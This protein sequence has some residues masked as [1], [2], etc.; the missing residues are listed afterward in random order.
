MRTRLLA[1]A[2]LA[3]ALLGLGPATAGAAA[4]PPRDTSRFAC[5]ASLPDP[6]TDVA[7]SVHEQ[8]IR[9]LAL[10]GFINGT[11]ST[12]FTPGR[13]VTRGQL[14]SFIARAMAWSGFPFDTSDQGFTD[15]AGSP[16]RDAINGLAAA[17]IIR[18]TSATTFSPNRPVTRAQAASLIGRSLFLEGLPTGEDVFSDDEGSV[19]EE[20]INALASVGIVA[21]VT[22]DR[23]DPDGDVTRGAAASMVARAN[24]FA[25][26]AQLSFP[27][28]PAESLLAALRGAAE[29]PGPGDPIGGGTVEL[30]K[31]AVDGLLCL[32]WD[33]DHPLADAPTAAHVH[34]GGAGV[35]GPIHLTLP[36]PDVAAGE[37]GFETP[38][39]P[40]L[41]QALIDEVFANPAGFYV[42]VHTAAFP[43]GAVRGQ[44]S[45]VGTPLGTRLAGTEEVPGPG[46]TAAGGDATVDTLAD[47]TTIC[48]FLFYDGVE[49]PLAAHIHEAAAGA[50][51][52]IVVTLPPFDPEGGVSDG[53]VGGLDAAL[54]TDLA[55][56]PDD[57]YVNVHTDGHPAGAVRG[58]L[59]TSA[60]LAAALGGA[61]EVPGPGDPDGAGEAFL[62]LI[63]D[64]LLCVRL[65]VRG[66]GTPT[67]AHIHDGASGVA[68]PIVVTLPTPT[69]NAS[70]DCIDVP[71]AVYADIAAN[72]ADF[73][74]NVHNAEHPA[75]AVRGQ[76][77]VAHG[78]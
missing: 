67:A 5:P 71:P 15:V 28:G 59:A 69:F 58:Q 53:C 13:A 54:V 50:A 49:E 38:C 29:V 44:L 70:F 62:D 52:P 75:G 3:T 39:V 72:P 68:G 27:A 73:Y 4:A 33:I 76:L 17:D 56:N 40:D 43:G 66:I 41:D 16:H 11:T 57:Y 37:R 14:A 22:P 1:T 36:F 47:G 35:A 51:G 23:F 34:K 60:I 46:E 26:E 25:I 64:G 74:V 2:V 8:A 20:A 10:Y 77:A 19:H 61:A 55:A 65:Q 6:F 31:T 32:T 30:V 42:N 45:P 48:S 12:T 21:G 78:H 24:D 7:G 63:G 18:G 9:C